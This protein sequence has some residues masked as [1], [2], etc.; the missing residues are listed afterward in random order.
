MQASPEPEPYLQA[1][2]LERVTDVI[3]A[4]TAA[5]DSTSSPEA[6]AAHS[7]PLEGQS[8]ATTD[9]INRQTKAILVTRFFVV[10]GEKTCFLPA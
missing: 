4:Y 7:K 6:P 10:D 5:S 3:S 8:A 1:R 2:L 9:A